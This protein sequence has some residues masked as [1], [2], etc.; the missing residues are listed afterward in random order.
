MR[1]IVKAYTLSECM[2]A[3]G[4]CAAAYEKIGDENIIF[5]EDRLTLVAERALLRAVGGTFKTN[6]FTFS[7]YVKA[8]GKAIS[9]QGSVMLV[10]EVM[11]RL[12]QENKLQCFTSSVGIAKNASAIYET[13]AQFSSSLI[14]PVALE[15]A[16]N[17]LPEDTLKRKISDLALIYEGY[18]A[19]LE[20]KGYLDESKYLTLLPDEIRRDDSLRFKNV[21]FLGYTSFTAR[22]KETIKACAETAKN[23]IGIFCGDEN[24]IYTN[25]AIRDFAEA[26]EKKDEKKGK[27]KSEVPVDN[28]GTP[29][30][31]EAEILRAGLFNPERREKTPTEN[32]VLFEG[33]DLA[34][35]TEF[36]ATKIKRALFENPDLRYRDFA[37]LT[38]DVGRYS[39]PLK[40]ALTEYNIPYF[41]DEKKTL[42]EHPLSR[43]I[44]DCFRVVKE[45]Y[46]PA[47]VQA[48]TQNY[49]FGESDEY[50]NYLYKFANYRGG[51]KRAIKRGEAVEKLFKLEPLE[52]GRERVLKGTENIKGRGQGREYCA[53]IRQLLVDF[54]VDGKIEKLDNA[55]TDVAQKKY[56]AQVGESLEKVIAEAERLLGEKE[57]T[58]GEFATVLEDGFSALEISLIPLKLD[59]VFIGDIAESRIEKVAYLFALG[60]TDEVPCTTGDTAIVSDKEIARLAEVKAMLEPTVAEVNLRSRESVCLNLCTFTEKLYLSYPLSSDGNEPST[61]EIF[62]YVDNL[63][64][65]VKGEKLKKLHG[66]EEGDFAYKCAAPLPAIRQMLIEKG[67]YQTREGDDLRACSAVYNA[68]ARLQTENLNGY[69]FAGEFHPYIEKGEALFFHDGRISPT[70]L[71]GYFG[72]PFGHFA[73]RGL[74]LKEREEATVLAVDAGS[75]VHSLLESTSQKVN[76]FE[77]EEKLVAF[78][79]TEGKRLMDE[80]VYLLQQDT[81]AGSYSSKKIL[82]EGVKVAEAIYRQLK[83]SAFTVEGTEVPVSGELVFGSVDRVDVAK[84]PVEE[85]EPA[86]EYVRVIDYKTGSIDDTPAAYYTGQKIQM[87]LYMHEVKGDRIPA[88]VFYFPASTSY[89]DE[90]GGRFRMKGFL[91]GDEGA[92]KAGDTS[93]GDDAKSEHFDATL[94][95]NNRRTKVMKGSTFADFLEYGV[96]VAEQGAEEIKEGFI[97]PTPYKDKCTYCKYGG[98]CGF[99]RDHVKE[100]KEQ[101]IE[102]AEIAAI[103]RAELERRKA[104]ADGAA[105]VAP[106][107]KED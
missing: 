31:G 96:L 1:K 51:A 42:L 64:C 100:R 69:W 2:E 46:S 16:K 92:L 6:V 52:S 3:M 39:M 61:S 36:V 17:K 88:G 59:A 99:Q 87:Q 89:S 54:D 70:S 48:M 84:I 29:L 80:S 35:E 74:H 91:N 107:E 72:C 21:I 41:V 102:P 65:D 98:M 77:T 101:K 86:V 67:K 85:G 81:K 24:E 15:K 26:C 62:R 25:R 106:E 75:F 97:A 93:L 11:N 68:L 23:V 58:V 63:F 79:A 30:E 22:A 73:E 19:I 78:A 57:M 103:A 32:I 7:R 44:L 8:E 37:L 104:Q 4:E 34:A 53:A 9:K 47:S 71:E 90:E 40:K 94:H 105:E 12:L 5:C 60:M 10:G 28:K 56:L 33:E 95:T 76:E 20:E 55:L 43:F 13:I 18:N 27:K 83:E 82:E 50:R 49:F 66:L 38:A 45:N 14:D